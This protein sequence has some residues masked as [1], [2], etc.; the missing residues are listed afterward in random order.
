MTRAPADLSAPNIHR[1]PVRVYWED[2]DAGGIVYH[3]GYVRFM[4]RG[5]TELLRSHGLDQSVLARDSD[6]VLF[7]VR[8]M[9][10]DFRRPAKLDD[11]LSIETS[12]TEIGG[13]RMVMTQQVLRGD[14]VLVA[15][16]VVCAA[17]TPEGRPRRV[18]DRI[19]ALFGI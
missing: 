16:K 4:E 11:M 3:A 7:A 13:A 15:A 12:V 8:H 9:D 18:P 2:T 14:E 17:I 5:R 19:R 6:P 1:H 10:I